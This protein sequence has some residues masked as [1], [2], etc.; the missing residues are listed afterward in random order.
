M[1]REGEVMII[2]FVLLF[3]ESQMPVFAQNKKHFIFIKQKT[4]KMHDE[5]LEKQKDCLNGLVETFL[6]KICT[7]RKKV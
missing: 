3:H 6:K 4:A 2:Q 1:L 5:I 7:K